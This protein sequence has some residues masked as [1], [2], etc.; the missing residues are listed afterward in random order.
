MILIIV[1]CSLIFNQY[2]FSLSIQCI[3]LYAFRGE[4]FYIHNLI[5]ISSMVPAEHKCKSLFLFCCLS[6]FGRSL[7]FFWLSHFLMLSKQLKTVYFSTINRLVSLLSQLHYF[8]L[9]RQAWLTF[10][11]ISSP[12]F[13]EVLS[14]YI[15]FWF[16]FQLHQ[17]F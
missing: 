8:M 1:H 6:Y 2:Y 10:Q 11:S 12:V 5:S 4:S 16:S 7:L 13:R 14:T 3:Y 9:F 17:W 15:S